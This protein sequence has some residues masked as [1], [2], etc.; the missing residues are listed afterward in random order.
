V[1]ALSYKIQEKIDKLKEIWDEFDIDDHLVK[2]N[3]LDYEV[4]NII[5][6]VEKKY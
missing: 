3:L 2:L 1:Q 4:T 5:L 6:N